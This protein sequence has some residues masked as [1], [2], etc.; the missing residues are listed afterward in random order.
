MTTTATD[1]QLE[2]RLARLE[3]AVAR[4]GAQASPAPTVDPPPGQPSQPPAAGG[5][6][7]PD[8]V[9]S[10]PRASRPN[11]SMSDLIGGRL[12][13][14]IG[15]V[16]TLFGIGLFLALAISRGWIGI[17]ARVAL[18]G[19]TSSALM[20]GGIWLHSRRGHTEASI[21]LVA[22]ATAG[23]FATL[24]VAGD[25][26][27]LIPPVLAVA[28]SMLVGAIATTLAIRWAGQAIGALGLLGALMSPVFVGRTWDLFTIAMLAVASGFGIWTVIAKRWGWLGLGIVLACAPQ[29]GIWIMGGQPLGVDLAVLVWFTAV[30]LAATVG[31]RFQAASERLLPPSAVLAAANACIVGALGWVAIRNGSTDA[32]ADAWLASL[33]AVHIG[34]GLQRSRR[35][36]I[37]HAV[38]QLLIAIGVVFA[39][40]AFGLGVSGFGLAAGWAG[41]AI[42]FAWLA[43]RRSEPGADRA[44]LSLGVGGHIALTLIRVLLLAPPIGLAAG[45]PEL[46]SLLAV[47]L[48]AA[49][50]LACGQLLGGR[51]RPEALVLNGLG[52]AA[53][54]YLTAQALG[55]YQLVAAWALE[56]AALSRVARQADDDPARYGAI[57]FLG[58][59][60]LHALILEAPPTALLTGVASLPAA[61]VALGAIAF[62]SARAGQALT[63]RPRRWL[64]GGAA[65]VLLYLAS[66]AIITAFQP[67]AGVAQ[68]LLD[69]SVRQ[70]GQVLL[71]ACWSVVG[72]V[73]LV[74]G[75]RRNHA[76]VRNVSLGL[77]LATVGKVFLYDLSTLTSIY[78][79]ASFIAL[80]LLL[81]AGAFAYQRHR[82][83]PL[84][85]MR[86]VH[87][88]Q[89]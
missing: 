10:A 68:T 83:P 87:P 34:L 69:L 7:A 31:T 65:G 13:A 3:Q 37:S 71:S 89:R 39:D 33:S 81:L 38:R 50:C 14:W 28:G 6:R 48:L 18:A 4:L 45:S 53:I 55:G 79:V 56:A 60:G 19:V 51:Q 47:A 49:S 24:L 85:D 40:I 66:V 29:W 27:G 11:A 67:E 22:V 52:L 76:F 43:R 44:L 86:T 62:A 80:G 72:L 36:P 15:G 82:P 41:A 59:A 9:V 12:L 21:V 1:P 57:G 8:W 75:L 17:E 78:R 25:V 61:A 88:S 73:G 23:L 35:L 20:I 64:L 54:A 26:Y 58:L 32:V 46:V 70:Q 16:A 30:G 77:L 5:S 2:E 84:P 63:E 74:I 42:G